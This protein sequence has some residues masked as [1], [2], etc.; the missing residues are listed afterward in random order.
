[1][2]IQVLGGLSVQLPTRT[3]RLGTP[4]QQAIF[5]ML[6]VQPG[7]LVTVDDLVDELWVDCPPRSAVANVQSYAA[8][9][10]RAFEA[11][12]RGRGVIIRQ[13]NGYRLDVR[14]ELID[15]VRFELERGAG[16]E[17][18]TAGHLDRARELL[19]RAVARWQGPMLAGI[20]L[21]PVLT[22]RTV[23][24]E[25][26]R[27]LA[28]ELLADVQLRSGRDDLAIPML[29][30]VVVRHPL[31]EPAYVL[32][33]RA[34]YER[35]DHAGALIVY[36]EIRTRLTAELGVEPGGDIQTLYRTIAAMAPVGHT[37][38]SVATHPAI[39]G[40]L[41]VQAPASAGVLI[42]GERRR[43]DPVDHLPRAAI[44]FVGREDV[45]SRLL[46]E[47]R[48]VEDRTSAVHVIDGMAGSGKT[49]LAV[50]VARHLSKRYPDA[51][52]FIDL[53]GYGEKTRIEP[54]AALAILL[55]QLRIPA[56]RIPVEFD[57]KVELWRRELGSRRSVIVLDN[58]V[59]SDQVL[60]LLPVSPGA[61]VLVTSR[62]RLADLDVGPPE[63]LPLM[64]LDEG[65]VLLARSAGV[66]RVA[67]EP[68]AAAEVVR[69]CG[70]LPLA[71]RLAGSRLA[72]RPAR[73]V[74]QLAALLAAEPSA[75]NQFEAGD[76]T[77]AR[78]FAASYGP[79]PEPAKR[80]FRM[81][82]IHSGQHSAEMVAAL[83]D[84]P[85]DAVGRLLDDLVDLHLVEEAEG[86]RYRLHDLLR[87]YSQ[88]Q[89]LA[90]E[91]PEARAL[92]VARLLDFALHA[93]VRAAAELH[94]SFDVHGEVDPG[95]PPR[96]DLIGPDVVSG[97]DW[98]ERERANLGML[99]DLGTE[100]GFHHHVWKIARVL[101]R[102]Y[103]VRGYFD[104]ILATHQA[105]L[106]S[107]K[108]LQHQPAIVAMHN[109]L[110]SALVKTG[111]HRLASTHLHA[112]IA[113]CHES[114]DWRRLARLRSNLS[115]VCLLTGN[116][117]EAVTLGRQSLTERRL[118]DNRVP[119][120]LPNLGIALASLGRWDEAVKIHRQH[121]FQARL[122][123][124]YYHLANA[125]SH[126]AAVRVRTGQFRRGVILL[127]SSLSLFRRTGHR[128][129][130]AEARNTLGVAYRGLNELDLAQWQHKAAFELA[131]DSGERH[132]QCAAL[133]DLGSTLLAMG[134]AASASDALRQGLQL[135]GRI[136]NPYEQGRALAGLADHFAH[137]D[138]AEAR[139]HWER[140]LAI[141]RRMG[142]PERFDAERRL[143]ELGDNAL[144]VGH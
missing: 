69:R 126:L 75:L 121:L 39:P 74:A 102:F 19:G 144:N 36:D 3:L 81:L 68:T 70:Y 33:I 61:V 48:R 63:S 42:A 23:A 113:L 120:A 79:L 4:K 25:E 47:T 65:L 131:A 83:L 124:D 11:F 88:A 58:A 34:L 53:C 103:H 122:N 85:L 111:S 104:D 73:K 92:A 132:A 56:E 87:R 59:S 143:A 133:N 95:P 93:S 114:G 27:L 128:Y 50:H 97:I 86:G 38:N 15:V 106:A 46:A 54:S 37:A 24:A 6:A 32:L 12:P 60:P 64:T 108:A 125:L 18:L 30:E 119:L 118:Y 129:G 29:R 17:A 141:F 20:P 91:R 115:V 137:V 49:T 98:L 21:G 43:L 127:K 134:D 117:D 105:G 142:V 28:V 67:E 41:N 77:L 8:N 66:A 55:R 72:R 14:P 80:A 26:E 76:R 57:A 96:P 112:A 16:R 107:A 139:R 52:L 94:Q 84:L 109:Y 123:Q 135:A 7:R 31:R 44:D 136:S 130:E 99:V 140:A 90:S 71:I 62:R 51:R 22:A 100:H 110:A 5:A 116:L 82:S 35:G 78:A 138:L 45:L 101:W 40:G 13:R 10:R 9:L 1:M 2:E 89:F